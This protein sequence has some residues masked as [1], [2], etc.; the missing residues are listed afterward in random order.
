[1]FVLVAIVSPDSGIL[2]TAIAAAIETA[3]DAVAH[4]PGGR[5]SA[6]RT[7]GGGNGTWKAGT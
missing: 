2:L 7:P 6:E 5:R 3:R 1:M 4:C